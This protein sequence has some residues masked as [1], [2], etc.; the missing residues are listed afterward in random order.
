MTFPAILYATQSPVSGREGLVTAVRLALR[1]N[2]L[3]VVAGCAC[4]GV[5]LAERLLEML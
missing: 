2:S 1:K 4:V 3:L 5:F